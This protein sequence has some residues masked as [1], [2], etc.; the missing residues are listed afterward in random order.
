VKTVVALDL[1]SVTGFAVYNQHG[2]TS[3]VL[4]FKKKGKFEVKGNM[5]LYRWMQSFL[6]GPHAHPDLEVVVEVPH[7]ERFMAPLRI[8]FGQLGIVHLFCA[9]YQIK[10]TEYR[11]KEIK[12]Y[13]TGKG[14]A[15][16]V[17]MVAQTQTKYPHVKDHNESDSL[18]LLHMHLERSK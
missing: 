13:W 5:T 14:N 2:V 11:S 12:K 17:A 10:L 4:N 8:L 18:A 3:G 15:D 6:E 9:M 1:G 16:K 7:A